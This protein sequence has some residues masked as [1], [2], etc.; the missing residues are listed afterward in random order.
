MTSQRHQ[1]LGTNLR[2]LVASLDGAVDRAYTDAGLTFRAAFTPVVRA[3]LDAESLSVRDIA[4]ATGTTPSAASQTVAQMKR[5][6]LLAPAVST[7][8]R[9]RRVVLTGAGLA[10]LPAIEQQWARTQRAATAL[11]AELG[12]DMNA[13][14]V[15]ALAALDR[16]PFLDRATPPTQGEA[17]R[18]LGVEEQAQARG[19]IADL[20]EDHYVFP[21]AGRDIASGLCDL[22]SSPAEVLPAELAETLT[23]VLRPKDAHFTVTCAEEH[24]DRRPTA[25][26]RGSGAHPEHGFTVT[27]E[28]DIA[29]IDVSVFLDADPA[30]PTGHAKAQAAKA[31]LRPI[32][33]S[34]AVILDLRDVPGGTPSM[35]SLVLDHV[36]SARPIHLLSFTAR[37]SV[38][39]ESWT[40]AATDITRRPD[41]PLY[42][43]VN[44]GTAS[45][46]ESCAYVLQSLRRATVI[47]QTTAG[48]ANP[49]RPFQTATGFSVFIPTGAPID[50]RTGT[51]WEG[52]GVTP[53]VPAPAAKALDH[54]RDLARQAGN[55]TEAPPPDPVARSAT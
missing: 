43:L 34:S 30:T 32:A 50:P 22:P 52:V 41:V 8:G 10:Q 9:E 48:A 53:D 36:L 1:T 29:V 38:L 23:A 13:V 20:I 24:G 19:E 44:E 12:V 27:I 31:L 40:A 39:E 2:R 49:G 45:A 3:L 4:A 33:H 18:R 55:A 35:V 46:A 14:V 21:D 16:Q 26:G 37:S 42:V 51:N 25:A 6:G 5:V 11:N 47:G 28:D 17:P 15:A 7:D 54:A